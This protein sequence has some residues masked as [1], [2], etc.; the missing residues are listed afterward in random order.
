MPAELAGGIPYQRCAEGAA[1]MSK[2]AFAIPRGV[3]RE[4]DR[5][6]GELLILLG[7]L[8]LAAPF[9]VEATLAWSL[10]LAGVAGAW[11]WLLDRSPRGILAAAAWVLIALGLG[12]HLSFHILLGAIPLDLTLGGGFVLLGAAELLLGVERYRRRW[13]ARLLMIAGG[14]AAIV[15]GVCVPIVWPAIPNWAGAV[16][17]ATMFIGFGAGLLLGDY[18]SR[19][20]RVAPTAAG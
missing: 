2:L 12:L 15:F 6:Y 20:S 7:L 5:L 8:S 10:F 1:A 4:A 18:Q 11:W 13:A 14:A 3:S 9:F 19:T 17:I 16:T